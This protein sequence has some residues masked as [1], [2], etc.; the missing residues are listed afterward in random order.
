MKKIISRISFVLG[1]I[2][3]IS[4]VIVGVVAM[5]V[6]DHWLINIGWATMMLGL[7]AILTCDPL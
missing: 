2:M 5:S 4:G 3:M 7:G 6:S 1:V